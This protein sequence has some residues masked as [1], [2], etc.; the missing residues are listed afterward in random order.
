[1][2]S[3]D[4]SLFARVLRGLAHAVCKHPKWFV[5]PQIVLFVFCVIY[6]KNNLK[7]DMGRDNLV[8]KK[9]HYQQNFLK[10]K[11]EFPGEDDLVVVV[12]S[13]NLDRNR[14]FVERIGPK[15]QQETNLF[16]D[17][18]YKGDVPSLG[19]KAL[20]LVP[21]EDLESMRKSLG[22]FKPFIE[23]FAQA[24]NLNSL[25]EI[26]NTE[27]RT[28]KRET[29]A[30]TEALIK[31]LPAL[32]R[33]VTQAKDSIS[34]PGQA[35]SPGVEA[36]FGAGQEAQEQ[37]YTTFA[38]GR[39]F[40]VNARAKSSELN[41]QAVE[42]LRELVQ[43]TQLEV[44]GLNI[45]VTGEPVI[46]LDEKIQSER[47]SIVASIASLIICS[48]IFIYAYRQTGRPLKA[49]FCLIIG[50]GFTM[51]F[52][53]LAVGHLNILTITFAPILI[54]LAIDFGIHY[55]TRF[56]E[57]MRRGGTV[58]EAIFKAS[59][60]TGQGI[61]TGAL[62]TA[63]AF[64][65]MGL[66]DFKGIQEMGIISGGGLVLCLVPMMTILPVL[67]M[68]GQQNLIDHKLGPQEE[69]RAKIENL[70]LERPGLVSL[71]TIGL[72]VFSVFQF[73]KV[74]FDYDLLHMQSKGL[75]AVVYI[76]KL[77]HSGTKS[78]LFAA[79]VA[80]D[81]TQAREFADKIRTLPSVATNSFGEKQVESM[82]TY[83]TE[84]QD[85]KL[86]IIR[87]IKQEIASVN[88]APIDTNPVNLEELSGTLWRLMGYLGLA[89]EDAKTSDPQIAEQLLTLRKG[90]NS[91]RKAM[92]KGD[93][94]IQPR[95]GNYQRALF[96]DLHNT[97]EALETQDASSRLQAK[98]LPDIMR[99][100]FVGVTGKQLL[101]VFPQKD[102]WE[103]DNQREFVNELR[104]I[105]PDD[106]VTG[107]PVQLLEYTTLLKES[108][109]QAALYAL[110][111]IAIMVFFHFRSLGW[112]V[113]ALLPVAIGTTWLLGLMGLYDIP[114]NPANIMTLP[115]VIGI[116]V[117]NGIHILN[118]FAE[119]Q[120][121]GILAKSTGKAVLVS[122]LTALTGFG[123]L[124]L[125]RH[126]GIESLGFVMSV[127][128]ATCMIAA[129]T[130]LPALLNILIKWK[131]MAVKKTQ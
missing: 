86:E 28:A 95:L 118:R 15:I 97:F 77:I 111:A 60:F 98:D 78:V 30:Q 17:V 63:V 31:A 55:I 82:G 109:Q 9:M 65:A 130:F 47:D 115:L 11:K 68:T 81:A 67:L 74:Y 123:C 4:K 34:R 3:F 96:E 49:V 29:N 35:P 44:P 14:Q 56:E 131:W 7:I 33:I 54:G 122:G 69:K 36:I 107:T 51:G 80:D 105:L 57:E 61:V 43:E 38:H 108:Y 25:F 26:I 16:T 45:G 72:C 101:M 1:M 70:W 37:I 52:T 127:G 100:R 13:E 62:T 102:V 22:D 94:E 66:T 59:V 12:E 84:N 71:I 117:T 120:K 93:P 53:T 20:L 83:L 79:V 50:L 113:L 41:S 92:L 125:G 121:P 112:V 88:F 8:G 5:Y 119:E 124:M 85:K 6:T 48:A 90:L 128:I 58:E 87:G 110:A 73:K 21:E 104:S 89:A 126:Q 2:T 42:R 129:L 19:R 40:L 24:T 39:I 106:R 114:F 18:F 75:Q 76:E 46:E 27:F 103:H 99:N 116:G 64:L 91:L 10:F 32:E 23:K